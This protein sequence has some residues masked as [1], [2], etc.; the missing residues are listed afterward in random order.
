STYSQ[1]LILFCFSGNCHRRQVIFQPHAPPPDGFSVALYGGILTTNDFIVTGSMYV[2]NTCAM[3][4]RYQQVNGTEIAPRG[5]HAAIRLGNLMLIMNGYGANRTYLNDAGIVD[6][7]N[8]V[9]LDSYTPPADLTAGWSAATANC[10]FDFS[11]Q[12]LIPNTTAS[13]GSTQTSTSTPTP[14]SASSNG[15]GSSLFGLFAL[16]ALAGIPAYVIYRRRKRSRT[17][18]PYW[19]PGSAS[20]ELGAFPPTGGAGASAT[21]NNYPLFVYS[22][23]PNTMK[24]GA[25]PAGANK[26]ATPYRFDQDMDGPDEPVQDG[27]ATQRH[28]KLWEQV[29]GLSEPD[30]E[31]WS[32]EDDQPLTGKANKQGWARLN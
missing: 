14:Q 26:T 7:V 19:V 16:L 30:Q 27:V 12:T 22:P 8:W 21:N 5:G 28:K 10:S 4:W 23:R 17:P 13:V 9:W 6:L 18:V 29:R 25:E 32:Y 11:S 31:G 2:L 3:K 24:G 20:H 15:G 1:F